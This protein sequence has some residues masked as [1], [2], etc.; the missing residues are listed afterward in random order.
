MEQMKRNP[1]GNL[2][3]IALSISVSLTHCAALASSE[4]PAPKNQIF[5][6]SLP[7]NIRPQ[8]NYGYSIQ[9]EKANVLSLD[10]PVLTAVDGKSVRLLSP[11]QINQLLSG[12]PDSSA[13]IEVCTSEGL[14]KSVTLERVVKEYGQKWLSPQRLFVLMR[15]FE[16]DDLN[17]YW[18]RDSAEDDTDLRELAYDPE[19]VVLAKSLPEP[20]GNVLEK[21]ALSAIVNSQETGNLTSAQ[22]YL[23]LL[24]NN[25]KTGKKL[26]RVDAKELGQAIR[27]LVDLDLRPQACALYLSALA[28]SSE[29]QPY[30]RERLTELLPISSF[31]P[32]IQYNSAVLDLAK[33]HRISTIANSQFSSGR[34]FEETKKLDQAL[35]LYQ[36]IAETEIKYL[37]FGEFAY[38]NFQRAALALYSKARMEYLLGRTTDAQ[39]SLQKIQTLAQKK[40]TAEQITV[41][42]KLPL[43]FPR[44]QDVED[45]LQN[46]ANHKPLEQHFELIPAEEN[47]DFPSVAN[48]Y[49]A[50]SRKD[51]TQAAALI[52]KLIVEYEELPLPLEGGR[53]NLYCTA[54]T[55]ARKLADQGWFDESSTAFSQLRQ[56][57]RRKYADPSLARVKE[58]MLEAEILYNSVRAGKVSEANWE[59]LEKD[60]L[61]SNDNRNYAWRYRLRTLAVAYISAGQRERA[62]VFVSKALEPNLPHSDDKARW[63]QPDK[64]PQTERLLLLLDTAWIH[65]ALG[66]FDIA[67]QFLLLSA[68]EKAPLTESYVKTNVA[69]ARVYEENGRKDEAEKI[70]RSAAADGTTTVDD[71]DA[72]GNSKAF[73]DGRHKKNLANLHYALAKLYYDHGKYQQAYDTAGNAIALAGKS[74]YNPIYLLAAHSAEQLKLYAAAAK[75]YSEASRINWGNELP[76][77]DFDYSSLYLQ[78]AVDAGEK[79]PA[80]K[81]ADLI[82]LYLELADRYQGQD[83]Q[84]QLALRKKAL[85]L[86]DDQDERKAAIMVDIG[87]LSEQARA[88]ENPAKL[89]EE[90]ISIARKAAVLAETNN[91][92]EAVNLWLALAYA[93]IEGKQIDAAVKDTEKAI[94]L[95]TGTDLN[96]RCWGGAINS[97]GVVYS[98][99]KA[100]AVSQANKITEASLARVI[101]VNGARSLATQAQLAEIFR[102]AVMDMDYEKALAV[103]DQLLKCDLSSGAI[104]QERFYRSH[105]GPSPVTS[106]S[107]L[108]SIV[109]E[110]QGTI[111]KDGKNKDCTFALTVINKILTKQKSIFQADDQRIAATLQALGKAY[112]LVGDFKNAQAKYLESV[113]ITQKYMATEEA[114]RNI[115]SD[116]GSVLEGLQG[117]QGRADFEKSI[118]DWQKAQ[119][120]ASINAMVKAQSESGNATEKMAA[121]QRASEEN[122]AKTETELIKTYESLATHPYSNERSQAL[123]NIIRF[124]DRHQLWALAAKCKAETLLVE[125][126]TT[127]NPDHHLSLLEDV[128]KDYIKAGDL[129]S[130][131]QWLKKYEELLPANCEPETYLSFLKLKKDCGEKNLLTKRLQ[132]IEKEI[133]SKE[134]NNYAIRDSHN[135]YRISEFYR[136]AGQ[137]EHALKLAERQCAINQHIEPRFIPEHLRQKLSR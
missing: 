1:A 46:L 121:R 98:L 118:N 4:K 13:T 52:S 89:L 40:F 99:K 53:Q 110:A 100:G 88:P 94:Q 24:L 19:L 8:E 112:L 80:F 115:Y 62:K 75:N 128:V 44:P 116:Y 82:K 33:A 5:A 60:L 101:A 50:V 124:A 117:A 130:A 22:N 129:T 76:E 34:Y 91:L 134:I 86:M 38:G 54:F 20:R 14:L 136:M 7:I 95:Y 93:E 133:M 90:R 79:A 72:T 35:E 9:F 73:Y 107:I 105:C 125:R 11:A 103:L 65:A 31:L 39:A 108:N 68:K 16:T 28:A 10:Q 67:N 70:L 30:Q 69:L 29:T 49:K 45:A 61:Y 51:R 109:Q 41:L 92:K 25:L 87:R 17:R 74:M 47:P 55:L 15:G 57:V 78:K 84:F 123:Q 114:M 2:C 63:Y 85:A 122:L 81:N 42:N 18:H 21:V 96:F 36:S 77:P 83:E 64:N 43:L 27:N 135:L 37:K 3:L 97:S 131:K 6:A 127:S 132:Q 48:F 66:N 137:E 126:Y 59:E 120:I 58:S 106:A 102:L 111:K 113:A 26:A 23:T 56:A 12:P 119:S 71:D 32:E 104:V